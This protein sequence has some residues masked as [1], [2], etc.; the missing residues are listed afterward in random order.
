M[1]YDAV[2]VGASLAGLYAG[3]RLSKAGWR[4]CVVDRRERIGTPVRCGEATG[5]RRELSRFFP[6]EEEWIASDIRG[7]MVH[8][9]DTVPICH[10]IPQCGVILHRDRLEQSLA[11]QAQAFGARIWLESPV[12]GL[13]ASGK[14]FEGIRLES[15]REIRGDFLIGADG[16]ESK[17]GQWAGISRPLPLDDAVSCVEYRIKTERFNDGRIHFFIGSQQIRGGYIWVFHKDH[18]T[19]LVGAGVYGGRRE[20]PRV[21]EILEQFMA[22]KLPGAPRLEMITG[23]V[24]IAVAPRRLTRANVLLIGDAAR[25]AN[26]LSA[27][28][29]MNTLE[30]TQLAVS[31][32]LQG[33][34][35]IR[36]ERVLSGYSRQW[37]GTPRLQQKL[38][39]LAKNMVLDA[40]DAEL[41]RLLAALSRQYRNGM[42]RSRT[43]RVSLWTAVA[44]ACSLLPLYLRQWR[45]FG[46]YLRQLQ[47]SG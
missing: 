8:F 30:A 26:P 35:Q 11:R 28:G 31:R 2:I 37:A 38:F 16:P 39:Y 18:D 41:E 36:P 33:R 42:D 32:L 12:V 27:G 1:R 44:I 46:G 7:A 10:D 17:V 21:S 47:A 40:S 4:V 20:G 24:P 15:G 23:C 43:F 5:N 9:N 22:R 29:I 6:I 25:Q 34:E 19:A 13:V 45:R 14:R 3:L